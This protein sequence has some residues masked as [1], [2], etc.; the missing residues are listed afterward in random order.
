MTTNSSTVGAVGMDDVPFAMRRDLVLEGGGVKG[1]GLAGA[2][3][4]LDKAGY[5]FPR[6]AGTS[7]GAIAAAL[8]AALNAAGKPLSDMQAIL[9]SCEYPKFMDAGK[10]AQVE[11]LLLHNGLFDGKYLT[12][13]LGDALKQIGVEKFGSLRLDDPGADSTLQPSQKYTLVVHTADITRGRCVRLP[14]Y[15]WQRQRFW[16]G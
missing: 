10:L 1:I 8:I 14:G 3:I 13:W 6:I 11:H 15:P 2:V 9:G 12:S 4:A 16:L 5:R 7:A